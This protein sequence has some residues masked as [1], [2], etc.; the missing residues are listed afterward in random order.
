M[1]SSDLILSASPKLGEAG[2]FELLRCQP[3][4]RDLL[5]I[6][7]R[8]ASTPK[9]LKRRIGNG[10]VYVRPVQRDLSLDFV[11]EDNEDERSKYSYRC[12]W[13]PFTLTTVLCKLVDR[14]RP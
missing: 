4:S 14:S 9:L 2:G 7:P 3:N 13:G 12:V 11:D 8:I 1:Q 10:K 6:G 5:P